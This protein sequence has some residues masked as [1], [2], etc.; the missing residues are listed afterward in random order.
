[1]KY[2]CLALEIVLTN[3]YQSP[4]RLLVSGGAEFLSKEGTI[5]GEP[6]GMAMFALSNV[7]LILKLMACVE[8]SIR[9]G[10]QMMPL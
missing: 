4:I 10:L 3:C 5:Q 7:S 9:L 2:V 6:L 1:M 8:R